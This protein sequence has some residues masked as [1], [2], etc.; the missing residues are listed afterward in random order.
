MSENALKRKCASLSACVFGSRL[1]RPMEKIKH[2]K[3]R[4]SE[5]DAARAMRLQIQ[6]GL[7]TQLD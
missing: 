5:A 2:I 3:A 1:S 4:E 6:S 7:I